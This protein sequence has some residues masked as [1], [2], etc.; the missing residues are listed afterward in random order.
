MDVPGV[1]AALEAIGFDRLVC[2]ELSRESPRAHQ[3]IPEAI[4]YL[5]SVVK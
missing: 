2:V 4:A 1:L 5:R 3:A